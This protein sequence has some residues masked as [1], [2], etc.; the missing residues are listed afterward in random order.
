MNSGSAGATDRDSTDRNRVTEASA[1][2]D[3]AGR[4]M[5]TG[6]GMVSR[7]GKPAVTTLG[8]SGRD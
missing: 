1:W 4:P 3:E 8:W 5:E 6:L 7:V 2:W